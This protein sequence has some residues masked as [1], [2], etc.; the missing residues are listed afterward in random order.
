MSDLFT[1]FLSKITYK[2]G[3]KFSSYYNKHL[4]A[5]ELTL[6]LMVDDVLTGVNIPVK[7]SMTISIES[8]FNNSIDEYGMRLVKD[9]V[10]RAES[11]EINEWLKYNGVCIEAPHKNDDKNT[12]N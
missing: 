12:Y 11:H 7:T 3:S 2:P 8:I 9:L 1:D 5:L 4:N 6:T 10:L